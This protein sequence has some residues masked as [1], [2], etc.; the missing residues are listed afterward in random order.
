MPGIRRGAALQPFLAGVSV[1]VPSLAASLA[2][3]PEQLHAAQGGARVCVV[4][5]LP[6]E[7]QPGP[8]I[9]CKFVTLMHRTHLRKMDLIA[10]LDLLVTR[11]SVLPEA[12][13]ISSSQARS[14]A[15]T[16]VPKMSKIA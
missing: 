5:D 6:Q 3:T 13:R 16:A 7:A 12:S 10:A 2:K 11:G 1:R 15:V 9:G 8:L 14:L 4:A